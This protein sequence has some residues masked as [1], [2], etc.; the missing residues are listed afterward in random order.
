MRQHDPFREPAI[1]FGLV[2]LAVFNFGMLAVA[3]VVSAIDWLN[4]GASPATVLLFGV[5]ALAFPMWTPI[6]VPR[7]LPA[8]AAVG[9]VIAALGALLGL[10]L[11]TSV[12]MRQFDQFMTILGTVV[13]AFGGVTALLET[14]SSRSRLSSP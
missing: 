5:F 2:T 12:P 4:R 10:Y 6:L 1:R 13:C 14:W 7:A 8:M 3:L 9:L 11:V